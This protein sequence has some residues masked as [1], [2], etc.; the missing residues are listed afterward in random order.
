MSLIK[1]TLN[2]SHV[3]VLPKSAFNDTNWNWYQYMKFGVKTSN[4]PLKKKLQISQTPIL[5]CRFR[6]RML[7]LV[8]T[9]KFRLFDKKSRKPKKH[10]F[11]FKCSFLIATRLF[12]P[13]FLSYPRS[14]S[15]RRSFELPRVTLK[16]NRKRPLKYFFPQNS[17][18]PS[19][20][21]WLPWKLVTTDI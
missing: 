14:L 19:K 9:L 5:F 20:V 18:F 17:L 12:G 15:Y 2:S 11:G 3:G 8:E 13:N 16:I 10:T 1:V 6:K 21:C 4:F 7:K